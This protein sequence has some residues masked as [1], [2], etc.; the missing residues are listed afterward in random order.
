MSRRNK[1][2]VGSGA[3]TSDDRMVPALELVER[4]ELDFLV[5]ECLAERTVAR[6]SLARSKDPEKGYTP[7]MP[8]RLRMVLPACV[9]QEV[10][11]VT[12]MGAA[13][14]L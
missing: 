6:E 4:G 12:N 2:R 11:I 9:K 10:R 13:N 3:G 14:P 7:S 8:E 1:V 5:F